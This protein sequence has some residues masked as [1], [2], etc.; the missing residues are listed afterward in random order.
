[1][2]LRFFFLAAI[3]LM[4]AG[5]TN[6]DILEPQE[7]ALALKP[8]EKVLNITASFEV[9]T[10]TRAMLEE[11]GE[12]L[13]K[14]I[15]FKWEKDIDEIQFCFEQDGTKVTN[16][17]TVTDVS[18]D[19]RT[20]QFTI[21]V[22]QHAIDPAQPYKLYAYRSGRKTAVT[23]GSE[24]IANSTIAVLP[25]QQYDY[26]ST[27]A[28]QAIVFSIWS[29]KEVSANSGSDID[30]SFKHLGS[31]MTLYLKNIGSAAITDLHSIILQANSSTLWMYNRLN[32]GGGAQFDMATGNF[33]SGQEQLSYTITFFPSSPSINANEIIKYYAWFV[34]KSDVPSIPLTLMALKSPG[35]GTGDIIALT[36][37]VI[38][39][40]LIV[41]KNYV[42]FATINTSVTDPPR[43][44][45]LNFT[46]STSF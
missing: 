1:M 44:Y 18:N 41:G 22:P 6:N 29:E 42:L 14:N 9:P 23:S 40:E 27:L 16:K 34:P 36:N 8:E 19:G 43:P 2:K 17:T 24:L 32:G 20:A 38:N 10:E 3:A 12:T 26:Q 11:N 45:H 37:K 15:Q 46:T 39:R 7:D 4:I 30:L 33:V 21:T 25:A 13:V 28:D 35:A 31:I 5:C